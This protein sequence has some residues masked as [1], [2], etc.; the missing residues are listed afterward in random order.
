MSE[1]DRTQELKALRALADGAETYES[2]TTCFN[3]AS[4]LTPGGTLSFC[5]FGAVLNDIQAIRFFG[6]STASEGRWGFMLT[7]TDPEGGL[8]IDNILDG[9]LTD[10][11][12]FTFFAGP[13][14]TAIP[15]ADVIG[16]VKRGFRYLVFFDEDDIQSLECS[17][18]IERSEET[19]FKIIVA[20]DAGG[21][22]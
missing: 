5:D 22:P 4:V 2:I 21:G 10:S 7:N 1:R 8:T 18:L 13:A 19:E 15:I 17:V 6:W 9:D 14:A 12:V 20:A 16:N 11:P 3:L